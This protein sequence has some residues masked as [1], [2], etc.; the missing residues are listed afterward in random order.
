MVAL[1]YATVRGLVMLSSAL[2]SSRVLQ[3]RFGEY[4]VRVRMRVSLRERLEKAK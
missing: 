3:A 2:S 4:E 1:E